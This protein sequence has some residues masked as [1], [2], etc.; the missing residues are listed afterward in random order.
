MKIDKYVLGLSLLTFAV[1]GCDDNVGEVIESSYIENVW[2]EPVYKF[3]RN[4]ISSVDVQECQLLK[5]PI[6]YFYRSALKPAKIK[7]ESTWES[8]KRYYEEGEYGLKPKEELSRS[9]LH[10][11]DRDKVVADFD[12]WIDGSKRIAGFYVANSEKNEHRNREAVPGQSGFVGQNI[13]DA[14]IYFVDEK[15]LVVAEAF[16]YAIMGAIYLDKILNVHLSE[17]LVFSPENCRAHEN[18]ELVNGRN[19]TELEHQL[20]LAKGYYDFWKPLTAAEGI[21]ALKESDRKIYYALVQGRML[22]QHF[23][24]EEA[25]E[26]LAIVRNEL[27]RVVAI[28]AMNLLLGPNTLVNVEEDPKYAFSFLSQAYGLIY[29]LQFTLTEE[30]APCF[31]Y[32]EV[33]RM[34]ADLS[35]GAGFWEKDRLLSGEE[36]AGSLRNIAAVIGDRFGIA[37]KDIER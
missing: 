11:K 5:E 23:Q 8:S 4:G 3:S 22:L 10:L 1:T 18:L 36:T 32:D 6:D 34:L 37:I 29:S 33:H 20:D 13:T 21:P 26:Q 25:K 14:N 19:Y 17:E 27:S 28:R 7:N 35:Q 31:S 2:V 24:Y 16:N 15:G 12:S 30:G 9:E